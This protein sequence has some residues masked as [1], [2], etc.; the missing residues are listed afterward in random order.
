MIVQTD[1][2]TPRVVLVG[3]PGAG[4]ST[5]GRKLAKELDVELYDTDAGIERET[6]RTIPE[7][8]AQDGEPEFRRIEERVVR[9]AILAERGVV[10]LG[11]GAVLSKET[12][13]LLRGRTVVYLEISV[14]EGLRRTGASTNRP[15]LNGDDPGA[16]YRELMRIRRPLYREVASVRVRTDGRSP[17]RVVRMIMAKL[18]LEPAEPNPAAPPTESNGIPQGSSR[19]RARRRARARAAA[20]RRA[21]AAGAIP[22]DQPAARG[23]AS[24]APVPDT[25]KTAGNQDNSIEARNSTAD[26]AANPATDPAAPR[27]R[28]RRRRTTRR[29][30]GG[31]ATGETTTDNPHTDTGNAAGPETGTGTGTGTGTTDP[32]SGGK[33]SRRQHRTTSPARSRTSGNSRPGADSSAPGE[34][35]ATNLTASRSRRRT[36]PPS[37]SHEPGATTSVADD[38]ARRSTGTPGRDG[39]GIAADHNA[40]PAEKASGTAESSGKVD[41]RRRRVASRPA[42]APE[43]PPAVSGSDVRPGAAAVESSRSDV[44]A[45]NSRGAATRREVDPRQSMSGVNPPSSGH[46]T[47]E[48]VRAVGE[49]SFTATGFVAREQSVGSARP[50]AQ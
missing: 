20:R 10:S 12:R 39:T 3:P 17:G 23:G 14:G 4:K 13:A 18:G 33:A 41:R 21:E 27:R 46:G 25:S 24:T 28:R 15:L 34:P 49:N 38:A 19:S 22:A 7:I 2:R 43:R 11:G 31:T 26:A 9:R 50:G 44:E 16:K 48:P 35:E 37:T 6:G 36:T 47:A 32:S 8:F 5:I 1:P 29:E 45:A 40:G 42:G 30:P